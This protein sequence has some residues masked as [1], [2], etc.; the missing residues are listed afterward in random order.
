MARISLSIFTVLS[1]LSLASASPSFSETGLEAR[2]Q[3]VTNVVYVTDANTFWSAI[4]LVMIH[5][6]SQT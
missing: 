2:A 1:V 4:A 3:D 5:F 6:S